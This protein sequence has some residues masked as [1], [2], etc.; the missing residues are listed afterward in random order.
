MNSRSIYCGKE[1]IAPVL[2]ESE[3]LT[4]EQE[5]KIYKFES[6]EWRYYETSSMYF[7]G[8]IPILHKTP[9][10]EVQDLVGLTTNSEFSDEAYGAC[11]ILRDAELAD[12]IEFRQ[13]L[14]DELNSINIKKQG[15]EEKTRIQNIILFSELEN[16][17]NRRPILGKTL[18]EIEKDSEHYSNLAGQ[19]YDIMQKI[20][21]NLWEKLKMKIG[22]K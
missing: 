6:R 16:P 3:L 15:I 14:V 20:K 4:D 22:R 2:E 11:L 5:F 10:P 7:E 17:E 12:H 19:A 9:K 18:S 21:P 1:S 8:V 13:E